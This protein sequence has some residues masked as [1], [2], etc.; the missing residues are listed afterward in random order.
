MFSYKIDVYRI[1]D[2]KDYVPFFLEITDQALEILNNSVSLGTCL[3]YFSHLQK[4]ETLNFFLDYG[5]QN[6]YTITNLCFLHKIRCLFH[7]L[8]LDEKM[9]WFHFLQANFLSLSS[10][11]FFEKK[12]LVDLEFV[13]QTPFLETFEQYS[14]LYMHFTCESLIYDS[15]S[16]EIDIYF[17]ADDCQFRL[18][19]IFTCFRTRIQEAGLSE[20]LQKYILRNARFVPLHFTDL[21]LCGL[22]CDSVFEKLLDAE[23]K[24][25]HHLSSVP[26]TIHSENI[27]YFQK[28]V[29]ILKYRFF[30]LENVESETKV[31]GKKR[32]FHFLVN[33]FFKNRNEYL[34]IEKACHH[35]GPFSRRDLLLVCNFL[36]QT[37]KSLSKQ[38]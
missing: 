2:N 22:V 9:T 36:L 13:L 33:Q 25:L 3:E 7:T 30:L 10:F 35:P 23:D 32:A 5:A 21:I 17:H 18:Y 14:D 34:A 20:L 15:N 19:H 8:G 38:L 27:I 31:G 29:S 4:P 16:M 28:I 6:L 1:V 24:D 11:S 26:E 37:L 12:L